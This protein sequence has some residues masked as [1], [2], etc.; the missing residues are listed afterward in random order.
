MRLHRGR[1]IKDN[2]KSASSIHA[3]S[4]GRR[5]GPF[6]SHGEGAPCGASC[7]KEA[8][9][10]I[11]ALPLNDG[12]KCPTFSRAASFSSYALD[13]VVVKLFLAL[14]LKHKIL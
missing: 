7:M 4:G 8:N 1:G 3:R 10:A 12:G 2:K 6:A 14:N 9:K 13:S 5:T 11:P